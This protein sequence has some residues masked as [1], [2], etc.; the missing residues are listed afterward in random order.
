MTPTHTRSVEVPSRMAHRS[1]D[2]MFC[3][4][5]TSRWFIPN[6]HQ[7]DTIGKRETM[8]PCPRLQTNLGFN[9]NFDDAACDGEDVADDQKDVP[10]IDELQAV[11]PAHFTA[12]GVPEVL[13]V[14]L[15]SAQ[16]RLGR[17]EGHTL[18]QWTY[19]PFVPF[20]LI[21]LIIN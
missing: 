15:A 1:Y 20:Q 10:A 2:D 17:K 14:F 11:G 12:Q 19:S 6:Q 18:K 9:P 7:R 8:F 4:E 16:M 21:L 3:G 13:H 5:E